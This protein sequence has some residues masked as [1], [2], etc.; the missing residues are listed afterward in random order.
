MFKKTYTISNWELFW[1]GFF[2]ALIG[3]I[4]AS[5]KIPTE[6][7]EARDEFINKIKRIRGD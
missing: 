3:G 5:L 6:M 4:W 7:C 2:A 1:L